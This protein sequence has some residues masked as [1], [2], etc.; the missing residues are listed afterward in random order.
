MKCALL[1]RMRYLPTILNTVELEVSVL[2]HGLLRNE[3]TFCATS[4]YVFEV[5]HVLRKLSKLSRPYDELFMPCPKL[6]LTSHYVHRCS[7]ALPSSSPARDTDQLAALHPATSA[8]VTHQ[9]TS[10]DI[11]ITDL[12]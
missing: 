6:G 5:F 12:D 2:Q 3:G 9:K 1:V 4:R 10:T 7:Q 11:D 8:I